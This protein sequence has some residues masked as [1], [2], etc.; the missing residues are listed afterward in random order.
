[1]AAFS[2]A[3]KWLLQGNKIKRIGWDGDYYVIDRKSGYIVLRGNQK[4]YLNELKIISKDWIKCND[5]VEK[6]D[7]TQ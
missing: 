2:T 3:L 5:A 6:K 7:V 4:L 1:M